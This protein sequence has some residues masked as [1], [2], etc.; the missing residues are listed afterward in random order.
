MAA[1]KRLYW[2][3]SSP[4]ITQSH[5]GF[6]ND[7]N[8]CI[9]AIPWKCIHQTQKLKWKEINLLVLVKFHESNIEIIQLSKN[10]FK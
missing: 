5:P 6:A 7:Y 4:S 3:E 2:N 10:K 8:F 9:T 1:A